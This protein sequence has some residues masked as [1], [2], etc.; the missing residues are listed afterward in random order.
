MNAVLQGKGKHAGCL[1]PANSSGS[2]FAAAVVG[3]LAANRDR[4]PGQQSEVPAAP[5]GAPV[6]APPALPQG[7]NNGAL[8][9]PSVDVIGHDASYGVEDNN[10]GVR[11][12]EEVS[13]SSRGGDC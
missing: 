3:A 6:P 1:T 9:G 12:C 5:L 10:E 8:P 11:A 2:A 4:N 13:C 7:L